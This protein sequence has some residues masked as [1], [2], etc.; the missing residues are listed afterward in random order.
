M[1]PRRGARTVGGTRFH[2]AGGA[3]WMGVS[4][5]GAGGAVGAKPC[6]IRVGPNFQA[7]VPAWRGAIA[8]D[9]DGDT[10]QVLDAPQSTVASNRDENDETSGAKKSARVEARRQNEND[11]A[12]TALRVKPQ[13]AHRAPPKESEP[14]RASRLGGIKVWPPEAQRPTRAKELPFS[15]QLVLGSVTTEAGSFPVAKRNILVPSHVLAHIPPNP[16]V[17]A[18][19][20][21]RAAAAMARAMAASRE[22]KSEPKFPRKETKSNSSVDVP[23]GAIIAGPVAPT[24]TRPVDPAVSALMSTETMPRAKATAVAPVREKLIVVP[25]SRPSPDDVAIARAHLDGRL[26]ASRSSPALIGL[27]GSGIGCFESSGWTHE[28]ASAF[29]EQLKLNKFSVF[30]ISRLGTGRKKPADPPREKK[31]TPKDDK[32]AKETA[33]DDDD[34]DK[35]VEDTAPDHRLAGKSHHN[36]IEYYYNGTHRAFPKS[37]HLRLRTLFDVHRGR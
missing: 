19:A 36:M 22:P 27:T 23:P 3:S 37:R 12:Y 35:N 34:N 20:A 16:S 31:E 26:R 21:S 30:A 6:V 29:E 4:R 10:L 18:A 32:T 24:V 9:G 11:L 17:K 8:L 15:A 5:F 14:A 13:F 2:G 33:G 25:A 28:S 7:T 1:Q